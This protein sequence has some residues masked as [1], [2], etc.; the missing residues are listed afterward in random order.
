VS[1]SK[2]ST[3]L[4]TRHVGSYAEFDEANIVA[5]GR[6]TVVGPEKTAWE[7]QT[8]WIDDVGLQV[9]QEG[10][11]NFY[12]AE[13][14]ADHVT[15]ALE[16]PASSSISYNGVPIGKGLAVARPGRAIAT[17]SSDVCR[18]CCLVVPLDRFFEWVDRFDPSQIERLALGAD[19]LDV[20][21]AKRRIALATVDRVLKAAAVGK[22]LRCRTQRHAMLEE[23]IGAFVATTAQSSHGPKKVGRPKQPRERIVRRVREYLDANSSCA[24]AEMARYA[25]VSERTL[26]SVVCEQLGISPKQLVMHRKLGDIRSALQLASADETVSA[27]AARYAVWD[28]GRFAQRY[29][30][31]FGEKPSET[32]SV[33]ASGH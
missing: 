10:G 13:A 2:K 28:L 7:Q 25:E 29:R 33:R 14:P 24:V 19:H 12:E 18:Y 20:D 22:G 32:L 9:F 23:L 3:P 16:L 30:V 17:H 5:E 11:A 1:R 26:R 6:T 8:L 31:V 21:P 27:I 4:L 15:L